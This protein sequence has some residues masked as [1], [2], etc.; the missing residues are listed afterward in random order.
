LVIESH[1]TDAGGA[2]QRLNEVRCDLAESPVECDVCRDFY[3][4]LEGSFAYCW[5]DKPERQCLPVHRYCN[6]TFV[7][8]T[9]VAPAAVVC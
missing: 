5:I 7:A 6:L 1:G 3:T 9:D 2:W 4:W 8:D